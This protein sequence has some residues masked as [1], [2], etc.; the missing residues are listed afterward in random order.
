MKKINW[1]GMLGM[2]ITYCFGGF[3]MFPFL[4]FFQIFDKL[5]IG[6]LAIL[7]FP[8]KFFSVFY[9]AFHQHGIN[10]NNTLYTSC[11]LFL[12]FILTTSFID[13]VIIKPNSDDFMI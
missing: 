11:I 5:K 1:I 7:Y 8:L 12:C 2:L 9:I 6:R 13:W 3:L 10:G 4:T